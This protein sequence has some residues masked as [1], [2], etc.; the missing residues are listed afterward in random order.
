M[1]VEFETV[2]LYKVKSMLDTTG[3]ARFYFEQF[4]RHYEQIKRFIADQNLETLQGA[5]REGF[6]ATTKR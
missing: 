4:L 5:V 2:I 3:M 6:V 1:P